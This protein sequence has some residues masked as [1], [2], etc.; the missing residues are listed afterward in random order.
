MFDL[1][2]SVVK[3]FFIISLFTKIKEDHKSCAISNECPLND[4]I[5]ANPDTLIHRYADTFKI[6]T[7]SLLRC[8]CLLVYLTW[9]FRLNNEEPSNSNILKMKCVLMTPSG[10]GFNFL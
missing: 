7:K 1:I 4:L 5:S 6:M 10:S 3:R 2:T 8:F 9:H